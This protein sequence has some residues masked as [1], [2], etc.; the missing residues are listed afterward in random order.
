MAVSIPVLCLF[1]ASRGHFRGQHCH[2]HSPKQTRVSYRTSGSHTEQGQVN[3]SLP[4]LISAVPSGDVLYH[5]RGT[6]ASTPS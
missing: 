2:F 3:K 5:T 4:K 1:S 6:T